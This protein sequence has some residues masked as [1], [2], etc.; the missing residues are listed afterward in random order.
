MAHSVIPQPRGTTATLELTHKGNINDKTI[1]ERDLLGVKKLKI[2]DECTQGCSYK[3]NFPRICLFRSLLLAN[4]KRDLCPF[5]HQFSNC[6]PASKL[7]RLGPEGRTLY[8]FRFSS[9]KNASIGLFWVRCVFG[10]FT[11]RR[12]SNLLALLVLSPEICSKIR[13][14]DLRTCP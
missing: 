9:S 5:E 7:H 2:S 4:S 1:P 13:Q 10:I 14:R 12:M 3:F 11:E 6:R 8:C